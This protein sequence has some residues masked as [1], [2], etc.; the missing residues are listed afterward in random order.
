MRLV[1]SNTQGELVVLYWNPGTGA[2]W[3]AKT[4]ESTFY[5][6]TGTL[7]ATFVPLTGALQWG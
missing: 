5:T 6:Q 1:S 7:A 4:V 2:P 3:R